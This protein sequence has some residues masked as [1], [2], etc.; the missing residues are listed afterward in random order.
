MLRQLFRTNPEKRTA[1]ELYAGILGAARQPALYGPDGVADT[2]E[3]RF[4]LVV[5]HAA[6]VILVLRQS[7]D[8]AAGRL[9]QAVFDTMFDDFD[10]AMREL[11]V[12]D[13]ALG[14]RI[15]FMAKGFYGRAS[16]LDEAIAADDDSQLQA[17]LSR[18]IFASETVDPRA[19]RL[20]LYVNSAHR[21]LTEQGAAALIAGAEPAF[22]DA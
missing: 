14:K 9:S 18:N 13:S 15:R 10:A 5:L 16:T 22:P 2:V 19:A 21:A 17:V 3:G 1:R 8:P 6:L 12:G 4:E 7:E 11:G 20:A